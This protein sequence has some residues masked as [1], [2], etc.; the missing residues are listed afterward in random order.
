M[1]E[2]ITCKIYLKRKILGHGKYRVFRFLDSQ[3]HS[4]M[5]DKFLLYNLMT[6]FS[7]IRRKYL[8]QYLKEWKDKQQ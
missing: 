5:T 2:K 1:S 3:R 8:E 6:G 7:G 4:V